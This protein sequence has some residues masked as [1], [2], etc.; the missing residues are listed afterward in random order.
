ML[1]DRSLMVLLGVIM[2]MV[3]P[4]FAFIP[5]RSVNIPASWNV[6]PSLETE[7]K[8]T[9]DHASSTKAE[10]IS[11]DKSSQISDTRSTKTIERI[12][13]ADVT[14]EKRFDFVLENVENDTHFLK[15]KDADLMKENLAI[16]SV[17]SIPRNVIMIIAEPGK[18]QEGFWKDFKIAHSFPV[19]GMLQ[20]CNTIQADGLRFSFNVA[21]ASQIKDRKLECEHFLRSNI[22]TLLSWTWNVKGMATGTLSNANF[23]I[24]LMFGYEESVGL[25]KDFDEFEENNMKPE[26]HKVK[27]EIHNEWPVID[28]GKSHNHPSSLMPLASTREDDEAAWNVFDL[29]SKIRLVLFRSLLESL[30]GNTATSEDSIRTRKSHLPQF[31]LLDL[32]ERLKSAENEKGFILVASLPASELNSSFDFLQREISRDTL[33]VVTGICTN[34]A[35]SVPFFA[36]GP[37]A[38]TLREAATIWD[39]PAV[40]KNIFVNNCQDKNCKNREHNVVPLLVPQMK[41]SPRHLAILRRSSRDIVEK[42]DDPKKAAAK[43][44]KDDTKK[45]TF[46]TTTKD[47]AKS[48]VDLTPKK[49]EAMKDDSTNPA[50]MAEKRSSASLTMTEKFNTIFGTIFSMIVIF[51][52]TS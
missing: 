29:F 12:S 16:E 24:P 42:L 19:E 48:V 47:D 50:H 17:S 32:L 36:Q 13:P 1:Q 21:L 49:E 11:I 10:M 7:Q 25:S 26:N 39:V 33:F 30:G 8:V 5:E 46:L 52:L 35:K 23:T 28:L 20:T 38:K 15:I 34:D 14:R 6:A 41:I 9:V 43:T 4:C 22:V 44:V 3:F 40:I 27:P 2:T 37:S 18:D 31:N 45:V 51:S